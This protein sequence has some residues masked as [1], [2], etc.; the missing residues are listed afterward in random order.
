MGP[1]V[2]AATRVVRARGGVAVITC[3][4]RMSDTLRGEREPARTGTRI[5]PEPV[6]IPA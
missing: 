2:R 3:A 1:K 6:T 4:D 5:V